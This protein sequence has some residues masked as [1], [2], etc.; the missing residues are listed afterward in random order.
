M[1]KYHLFSGQYYDSEHQVW[2]LWTTS[3]QDFCFLSRYQNLNHSLVYLFK[4]VYDW[5]QNKDTRI[6]KSH[7]PNSHF[8]YSYTI[9]LTCKWLWLMLEQCSNHNQLILTWYNGLFYFFK[10][11]LTW[12]YLCTLRIFTKCVLL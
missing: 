7:G 3:I 11:S 5:L 1:L 2:Q 4:T 10:L 8:C 9:V 6:L 12:K